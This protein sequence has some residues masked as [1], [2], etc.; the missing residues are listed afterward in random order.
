[1][2]GRTRSTA[3]CPEF[4]S[5]V[6]RVA[7]GARGSADASASV[8]PALSQSA[9]LEVC[10]RPHRCAR[11]AARSEPD[12]AA[13]RGFEITGAGTTEPAAAYKKLTLSDP[14]TSICCSWS[15]L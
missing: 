3:G 2:N 8:S 14:L 11:I 12:R 15:S 1:M 4:V 9:S 5:L 6:A 10:R 7:D 13:R